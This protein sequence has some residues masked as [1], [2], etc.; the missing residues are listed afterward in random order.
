M[1]AAI[2][3][4]DEVCDR[5]LGIEGLCFLANRVRSLSVDST[6]F[7]LKLASS[8]GPLVSDFVTHGPDFYYSTLGIHVG[9][10]DRLTFLGDRSKVITGT[11]VD[12]RYGSN[13]L[14]KRVEVS[15]A[16]SPNRRLVIPRGVAHTFDNLVGIVTRDEPVWYS[17]DDNAHWNVNNDLISILRSESEFPIVNVNEYRLPDNLHQYMTR[18]SQAA[19]EKPKAYAA[20]FKLRIAGRDQYVMFQENI[21]DNELRA[22]A[23]LTEAVKGN[24]IEARRSKYA[25][26]G[27]KSWTLV[28]NTEA[29]VCDVL[30]ASDDQSGDRK[31]MYV[32][33]RTRKWYTVLTNEG[34]E[35]RI[36]TLDLR[37]N[38]ESFLVKESFRTIAD[39]R[40]TYIIEPGVAYR[41]VTPPCTYF[42]SE[43]EVFVS[44]IEPR[45]D[46]PM[47][48][49]D[50]E[51]I[52]SASPSPK[53]PELPTL[54]CP[55]AVVRTMASYELQE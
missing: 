51:V 22:V 6:W 40:V 17:A 11:F 33:R 24:G 14:H 26:T 52:D 46:I 13:A 10:D 53:Q 5:E 48:G 18:L 42:R 21:W 9:Q 38:S 3:L 54:R 28:P 35:V 8:P 2:T 20:R 1:T 19:L 41:F 49:N 4:S 32:H 37:P 7:S 39:P 30:L 12:C 23:P 31:R 34:E 16:P 43:H 27:R 47:F 45:N 44:P 55:E 50:I 36:D 29:G 15:F 25:V